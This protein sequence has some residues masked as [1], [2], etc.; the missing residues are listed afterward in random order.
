MT[1]SPPTTGDA[2][3]CR[4]LPVTS[5]ASGAAAGS[6]AMLTLAR[7]ESANALS[8]AILAELTTHC[9]AL[10]RPEAGI[11]AVVLAGAGRHFSA[12][13]DLAWMRASA[14][15]S[16]RDNLADAGLLTAAFEAFAELPMPT[17]TVVTGAAYGGAVGFAAAAD[18]TLAATD[19]RFC[20][21]EV[22]LGLLPAVILPYLARKL[23]PGALRHLGL[24][25]QVLSAT[26]AEAH[27]LVQRVA[28]VG[29]LEAA[30]R[31]ELNLLLAAAP[32]AQGAFKA[33]HRQVTQEAGRQGR[34]TAEAI[35]RA[36]TSAE[37]QAGL[38]AFF[39]KAEAPWAAELSAD[40][41]LL[42]APPVP[43]SAT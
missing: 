42:P 22:R 33:L 12:G 17:I 24:S 1:M 35:A 20:L 9:T 43:T 28:P 27:G 34:Y 29:E 30:L 6:V 11:R 18:I 13:A 23:A 40:I 38:Q 39:A 32:G 31:D 19:A 3:R 5:K 37:G 10:A 8:P 7:P 2:V 41:L 26:A 14:Q 16:H 25:A 4:L 21:S 36:R 15:L